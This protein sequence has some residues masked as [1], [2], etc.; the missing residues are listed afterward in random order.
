MPFYAEHT[1]NTMDT[2]W[3]LGPP[4]QMILR[5]QRYKNPREYIG[6]IRSAHA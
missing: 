6:E 1:E 4:L 3:H 2:G 5:R